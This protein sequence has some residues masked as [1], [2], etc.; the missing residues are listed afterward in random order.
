MLRSNQS[1]LIVCCCRFWY[2]NYASGMLP[3]HWIITW[4]PRG[5]ASLR[6]ALCV[7]AHSDTVV[8]VLLAG[9]DASKPTCTKVFLVK[10]LFC[11][12]RFLCLP[13]CRSPSLQNPTAR[14]P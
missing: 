4:D 7:H 9:T 1:P 6:R 2:R 13:S 11:S 14:I 10:C 3:A 5:Q 8:D 12:S